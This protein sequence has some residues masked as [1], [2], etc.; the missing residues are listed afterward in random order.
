MNML[1]WNYRGL[2]NRRAVDELGDIIQAKD[3]GIVFLSENVLKLSWILLGCSL[4]IMKRGVGVWP[5]CGRIVVL[6]GSIVFLAII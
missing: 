3:L 1:A 5:F 4:S 6:F 2:G